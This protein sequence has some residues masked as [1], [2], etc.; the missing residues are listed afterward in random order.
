MNAPP[1]PYNPT[2]DPRMDGAV[3]YKI[4]HNTSMPNEK[5]GRP[6]HIN[7]IKD[8]KIAAD[9]TGDH[10]AIFDVYL[11]TKNPFPLKKGLYLANINDILKLAK[12]PPITEKMMN[13][14]VY[15][16]YFTQTKTSGTF[17]HYEAG[18]YWGKN[19]DIL[20]ALG[21]DGMQGNHH[22]GNTFTPFKPDHI[23]NAQTGRTMNNINIFYENP[24]A[25]TEMA[26]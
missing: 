17:D 1:E 3:S 22:D 11:A 13:D 21:Y 2:A 20:E 14:F 23:I 26:L 4:W 18:Y 8:R 16:L 12:R 10:A 9:H 6:K 7:F 19:S 25:A 5:Y 15:E 24:H